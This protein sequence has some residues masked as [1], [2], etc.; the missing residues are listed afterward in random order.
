MKTKRHLSV[1]LAL[2]VFASMLIFPSATRAQSGPTRFRGDTGVI[3]L[4]VGQVLRITLSPEAF[5][6]AVVF[7]STRYIPS[8]CNSDGVCRH[9][10]Q[11]Q[12]TTAPVNVAPNQAASFEVQGNGNGVRVVVRANTRAVVATASIIDIATG[13]VTSHVIMANTE[14]DFH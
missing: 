1:A 6:D 10:V 9:T 7:R 11:S 8:G 4:A 2:S 12:V 5:E 13:E 14:G 3:A